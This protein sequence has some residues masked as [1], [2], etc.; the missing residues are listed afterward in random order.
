MWQLQK[1]L[2]TPYAELAFFHF[3]KQAAKIVKRKKQNPQALHFSEL[4]LWLPRPVPPPRESAVGMATYPSNKV[5]YYTVLGWWEQIN[6]GASVHQDTTGIALHTI[7]AVDFG[8]DS[9]S[10]LERH[11]KNVEDWFFSSPTPGFHPA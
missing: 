10:T 9:I 7:P 5:L 1:G 8:F 11:T 6:P 3:V 4:Q 2:S